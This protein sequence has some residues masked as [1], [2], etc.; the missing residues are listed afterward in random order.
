ME[1]GFC[2]VP[3]SMVTDHLWD[4][5]WEVLATRAVITRRKRSVGGR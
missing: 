2:A 1:P 3:A 4:L 5:I